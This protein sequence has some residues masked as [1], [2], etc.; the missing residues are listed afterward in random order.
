M[1]PSQ[2]TSYSVHA[3]SA[4]N[5]I[6]HTPRIGG[7]L[8]C[9]LL[10]SLHSTVSL[11]SLKMNGVV[12]ICTDHKECPYIQHLNKIKLNRGIEDFTLYCRNMCV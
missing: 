6:S 11:P 9:F 1:S 7:L 5:T 4:L 2:L 10:D 3:Y 12:Q 8:I